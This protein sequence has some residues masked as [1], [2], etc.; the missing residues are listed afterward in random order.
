MP[1]KR[2]KCLRGHDRIPENLFKGGACKLCEKL[3]IRGTDAAYV[4]YQD[5]YRKENRERLNAV[6]AAYRVEQKEEILARAKQRYAENPEPAK[7]Q[8]KKW[9]SNNPERVKA[10]NKAWVKANP[11]RHKAAIAKRRAK[12]KETGDSFSSEEWSTLCFACNY[13]CLSCTQRKP[14]VPDHV[15]PLAKGGTSWLYN[16]QPLCNSCNSKKGAKTIDYRWEV[17]PNL[18]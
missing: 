3:R 5:S 14:L 7:L 17:Q 16:I 13:E 11:D 15:V 4:R 18:G 1:P 8:A 9:S 12:K 2:D 10:N 6:A